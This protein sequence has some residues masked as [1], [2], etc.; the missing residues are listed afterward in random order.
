MLAD[1]IK[2]VS[3]LLAALLLLASD[4]TGLIGIESIIPVPE[5]VIEPTRVVT[6][7]ICLFAMLA[8][9][10][11]GLRP[12]RKDRVRT[13]ALGLAI[14]VIGLG[15][16]IVR[17]TLFQESVMAGD[18]CPAPTWFIVPDQLP[19]ELETLI[20]ERQRIPGFERLSARD[21]LAE[22][23]CDPNIEGVRESL[24]EAARS[25]RLWLVFLLSFA[26]SAIF[27]G[28]FLM[29]W[30][31]VALDRMSRSAP[32]V[33]AESSGEGGPD[34]ADVATGIMRR[35]IGRPGL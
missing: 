9:I 17:E 25:E 8:I 21:L 26:K 7:I 34:L 24:D 16:I 4:F 2:S 15:A 19:K 20:V 31:A 27:A 10:V 14:L 11:I 29:L 5:S 3:L 18:G 35:L 22:L 28:L 1:R 23:V 30:A 12:Y 33:T 13:V 6:T 32:A